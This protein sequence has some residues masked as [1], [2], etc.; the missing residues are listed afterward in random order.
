VFAQTVAG[1]VAL[2]HRCHALALEKSPEAFFTTI[3]LRLLELVA[4]A[5]RRPMQLL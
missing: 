1:P 3:E 5:L 2:V 4:R